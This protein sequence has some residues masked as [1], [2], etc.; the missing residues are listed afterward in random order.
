MTGTML[1]SFQVALE[2][3][4]TETTQNDKE[5]ANIHNKS[6][7]VVENAVVVVNNGV[8]IVTPPGEW[9]GKLSR[10]LRPLCS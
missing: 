4:K 1:D 9:K 2:N 6:S 10:R 7:A 5:I 3:L 8:V